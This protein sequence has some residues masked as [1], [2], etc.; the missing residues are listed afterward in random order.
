SLGSHLLW[1]AGYTVLFLAMALVA[2]RRDEGKTY[3]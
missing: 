2:Y 1:L 3:G